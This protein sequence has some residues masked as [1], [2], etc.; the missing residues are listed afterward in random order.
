MEDC[1]FWRP[2]AQTFSCYAVTQIKSFS[3]ALNTA[4]FQISWI[5]LNKKEQ[6]FKRNLF[7]NNGFYCIVMLND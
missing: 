5:I 3:S 1:E 2:L 4:A 6:I 7:I